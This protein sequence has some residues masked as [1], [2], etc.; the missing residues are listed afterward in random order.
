MYL[1]K[2]KWLA[3]LAVI[4][5]VLLLGACGGKESS[6][7]VPIQD[8]PQ[9]GSPDDFIPISEGI[10]KHPV[11]FEISDNPDRNSTVRAVYVFED[12]KVTSYSNIPDSTRDKLRL[13]KI[14][15]LSDDE[16]I[17]I[18]KEGSQSIYEGK[19]T[20]DITLDRLGQNS[21]KLSVILENGY[22]NR[23]TFELRTV[24]EESRE[25]GERPSSVD[26]YIASL[27]KK[28]ED[29]EIDGEYI[30]FPST[31][32]EPKSILS[33]NRGM[34]SQKIFDTTYSGLSIG[35]SYS[36]LTRVDDSFVG[37]RLD[38]PDT[39]KKNVTIE[40]K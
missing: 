21:E 30:T 35:D 40:G 6:D 33:I 31:E 9:D 22:T 4:T 25:S 23:Q 7:E 20:L 1:R 36:L 18:A 26:E 28:G 24:Y 38:N 37:F 10:E 8:G 15:D 34:I 5:T 39:D 12:G 27:K 19:Y 16:I 29:F 32:E 14:N 3:M 11:W 2:K 17:Q 13:E